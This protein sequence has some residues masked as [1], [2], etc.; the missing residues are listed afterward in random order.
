MQIHSYA[1]WGDIEGVRRELA[2]GVDVD[3]PST[4]NPETGHVCQTPLLIAARSRAAGV[5]ML[6]LLV[7][8]GADV[9]A[10]SG[11]L[12]ITP[13]FEAVMSGDIG[14]VGFLVE[15]GADVNQEAMGEVMDGITPI[16]VAADAGSDDL[17]TFFLE[18]GADT[19]ATSKY[20]ESVL[21]SPSFFPTVNTVRLA[22]AL[23][24]D[25]SE[26]KW[27]PL[28]VA[29][30]AG[31]VDDVRRELNAGADLTALEHYWQRT[32]WLPACQTGEVEKARLILEA[33]ASADERDRFGRTGLHFAP[34]DDNVAMVEW[35]LE[36]GLDVDVRNEWEETP[37]MVAARHGSVDCVRHLLQAGADVHAQDH[38]HFEAISGTLDLTVINVLLEAGADINFADGTGHTVLMR[39]A[40]DGLVE[41]AR[42]L[43]SMGAD[44][45]TPEDGSTPLIAACQA[46][47]PEMVRFLLE[48]GA[49]PNRED[50]DI[51]TP[52]FYVHSV[53]IARALLDAG[54]DPNRI[55]WVGKTALIYTRRWA[56]PET[57]ALLDEVTTAP[58]REP[59]APR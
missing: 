23:G 17:L 56:S 38:C 14:K 43:V 49:D 20:R 28:M 1:K 48:Q 37:L 57:V 25:P 46:D 4:P 39:A 7:E 12:A 2:K 41:E 24:C 47:E 22:L 53:E 18:R 9:N 54:A 29:I 15:A 50:F 36:L 13:L 51:R 6:R 27:T 55:D 31:T 19:N 11:D 45:N 21:R 58:D 40:E 26:L 16:A 34:M 3:A 52:L 42:E 59:E 5:D 32:L 44:P 8:H 30:A 10:V 33:G 35:L